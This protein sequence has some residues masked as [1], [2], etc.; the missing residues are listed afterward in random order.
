MS[1][2]LADNDS[3]DDQFDI[4]FDLAFE[5]RRRAEQVDLAIDASAVETMATKIVEQI[6]MFP[7]LA[8]NHGRQE[9]KRSFGIHGL[10]SL[11]HLIACLRCNFGVAF[12]TKTGSHASKQDT[13]EVVEFGDRTHGRA[14]VV[15]GRLL[16]DG[17][18]RAEAGKKVDVGFRKLANELA[19]IG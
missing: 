10:D 3:I 9:Q 8:A 12:W 17:D 11:Y 6:A 5:V 16:T 14:R 1:R 18:R 15:S 2:G 13:Q 7:F 4:V 19:S